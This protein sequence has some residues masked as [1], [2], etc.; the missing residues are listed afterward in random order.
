MAGANREEIFDVS[1]EQYYKA[2]T[3]FENYP[4]LLPEVS[5]IEILEKSDTTTLVQYSVQI[6]KQISYTLKMTHT[7]PTQVEWHLDSGSLFKANNGSWTIEPLGD[8]QCKVT[9]DL[10]IALKVFAPKTI[11]KKLVAVNLPRMMKTFYEHAKT[12]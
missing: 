3:D 5:A 11:T 9:Y 12:L 4:E 10:D 2:V 6:V 8:N 1:A 7:F